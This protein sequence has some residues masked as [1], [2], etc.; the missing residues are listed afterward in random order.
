MT[1]AKTPLNSQANYNLNLEADVNL[2]LKVTV[3]AST[4]EICLTFTLT[5]SL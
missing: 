5:S 2:G 3:G 4:G 1:A